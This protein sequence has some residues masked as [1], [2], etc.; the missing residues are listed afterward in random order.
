[1]NTERRKVRSNAPAVPQEDNKGDQTQCRVSGFDGRHPVP[2]LPP[3]VRRWGFRP[4]IRQGV[5]SKSCVDVWDEDG[6]ETVDEESITRESGRC[7]CVQTD[8]FGEVKIID[9]IRVRTDPGADG[10]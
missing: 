7:S 8:A 3:P 9:H 10:T 6:E 1:V 4:G 2:N 5:V